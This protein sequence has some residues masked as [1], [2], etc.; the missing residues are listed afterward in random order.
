MHRFGVQQH[1]N[2]VAISGCTHIDKP[3]L[4]RCRRVALE[5]HCK[6]L[7]LGR[8]SS[9]DVMEWPLSYAING[10]KRLLLWTVA[11]PT[12]AITYK[13][14][15]LVGIIIAIDVNVQVYTTSNT[16]MSIQI[17]STTI[18]VIGFARTILIVQFQYKF[19]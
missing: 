17:V 2:G 4:R 9:V 5:W 12:R 3:F 14:R 7:M 1:A 10:C 16:L 8:S 11:Y 13:I 15:V 19:K 18:D 6:E